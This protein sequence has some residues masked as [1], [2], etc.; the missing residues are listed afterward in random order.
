MKKTWTKPQISQQEAS[1]EVT[2]YVAAELK[3]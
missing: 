3:S 1:L 2:A